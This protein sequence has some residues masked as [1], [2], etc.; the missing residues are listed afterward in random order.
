MASESVQD[1]AVEVKESE[2]GRSMARLAEILRERG[3]D[4]LLYKEQECCRPPR[5]LFHFG[6]FDTLSGLHEYVLSSGYEIARYY[7][8][9][10]FNEGKSGMPWSYEVMEFS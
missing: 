10:E 2:Q 7:E 1:G 4:V 5:L 8:A 9:F 6:G 3:V